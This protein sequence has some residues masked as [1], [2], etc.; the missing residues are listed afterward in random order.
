MKYVPL[1][2]YK[3][4]VRHVIGEA[5]IDKNGLVSAIIDPKAN[6]EIVEL[7]KGNPE[8]FSLGPF[9]A[10]HEKGVTNGSTER[11]HRPGGER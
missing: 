6:P 3:D 4:G 2:V 10:P 11:R 5:A 1:T 8:E 9:V 7:I